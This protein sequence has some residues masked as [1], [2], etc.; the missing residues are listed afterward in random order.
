MDN[1]DDSNQPLRYPTNTLF[2]IIDEAADVE[3]ARD[4][5]VAAGIDPNVITIYQGEDQASRAG[6]KGTG[7]RERLAHLFQVVAGAERSYVER[8]KAA[9]L[10]GS[11]LLGVLIPDHDLKHTVTLELKRHSAYFINFFGAWGIEELAP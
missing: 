4:S 1:P 7:V 8:H 5:L 3:A 2:C 9:L 11:S 10:A 6:I